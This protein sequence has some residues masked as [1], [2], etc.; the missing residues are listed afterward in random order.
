MYKF[1][2]L[3]LCYSSNADLSDANEVRILWH[4]MFGHLNYIFLLALSKEKMVEGLLGI[5]FSKGT[6]KGCI[7]GK[8]AECKY[9]KG[10]ERRV[11]QVL[12]FIHSYLIGPLPR[13]SYENS[14]YAINIHG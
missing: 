8:H 10:K 2:Q 9:D 5:N 12:G 3:L 7:V 14:R 13:P 4:D 6:C 1:S 11:V